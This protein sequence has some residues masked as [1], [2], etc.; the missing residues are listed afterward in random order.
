MLWIM[1]SDMSFDSVGIS[2]Q[3][4][5]VYECGSQK[6]S[7][8]ISTQLSISQHELLHFT[9]RIV[10]IVHFSCHSRPLL[11]KQMLIGTAVFFQLFRRMTFHPL[12]VN[13]FFATKGNGA[14]RALEMNRQAVK[15]HRP[16]KPP[17]SSF[18]AILLCATHSKGEFFS[19]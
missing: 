8:I 5:A 12:Y 15:P 1:E 10:T 17:S 14:R 2:H 4:V 13:F 3:A 19:R 9:P 11:P 18:P 16:F 6:V 7:L